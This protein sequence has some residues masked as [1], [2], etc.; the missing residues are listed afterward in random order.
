MKVVVV[1]M[2]MMMMMMRMRMRMMPAVLLSLTRIL[3]LKLVHQRLDLH[4]PLGSQRLDLRPLPPMPPRP[5]RRL[6]LR[7]AI[8]GRHCV[9]LPK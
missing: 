7:C 5:R 3:C 4:P 2:K 9:W 8:P 1:M 6:L